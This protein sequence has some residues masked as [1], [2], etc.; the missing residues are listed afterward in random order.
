[1]E[2]AR[3]LDDLGDL[4]IKR[5]TKIHRKGQEAL[6]EYRERQQGRTDE[7]IAILHGV[8]TALQGED[9]TEARLA[10]MR[11]VVGDQAAR[12]LED[13]EAHTAYADDNYFSLLWRF[14]KSHRQTLFELLDNVRLI[15]TSRDAAIENALKFVRTHW[16][17]RRDWLD[18]DA[19]QP[20]DLTWIF[21]K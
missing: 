9:T 4:L 7:L 13:C 14:Y 8:V 3:T 16:T 17:S 10:A 20:L 12:I 19:D 5:M 18:H 15:A 11:G 21:E 2:V 6:A 1:M